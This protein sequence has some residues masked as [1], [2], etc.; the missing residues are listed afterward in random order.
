MKLILPVI[1]IAALVSASEAKTVRVA[2]P[3]QSMAQIAL[4]AA[5]EKGYFQE[6]DWMWSLSSC[7][8]PW[9]TLH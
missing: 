7:R 5:Q 9:R 2:V 3:S 4:Y 6:K 8:R 1:V